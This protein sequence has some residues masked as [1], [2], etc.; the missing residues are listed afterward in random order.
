MTK[1]HK[2]L[3]LRPLL[4]ES[5]DE[6]KENSPTINFY[7]ELVEAMINERNLASGLSPAPVR[8]ASQAPN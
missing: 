3:K 6:N 2:G 8:S 4:P 5:D 1:A 7:S